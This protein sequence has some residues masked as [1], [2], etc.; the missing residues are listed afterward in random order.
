MEAG[1]GDRQPGWRVVVR[2]Q[3]V[4]DRLRLGEASRQVKRGRAESKNR[5]K[6]GQVSRMQKQQANSLAG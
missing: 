4:V 3:I 2:M 6:K 1:C 5:S